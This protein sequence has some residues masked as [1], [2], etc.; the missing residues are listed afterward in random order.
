M[1]TPTRILRADAD[2]IQCDLPVLTTLGQEQYERILAVAETVMARHGAHTMTLGG[3]T[4]ALRMSSG[5]LRRHFSDI[6]GLLA[7]LLDRHLRNIGRA[8]GEVPQDAVD[9]PQKLRAAYLAT[10]RTSEGDFTDAH[11]LMVRARL[12]LPKGLLN[13]IEAARQE[14]GELV[15]PGYA[16]MT[17][18]VLDMRAL[19]GPSIEAGLAAIAAAEQDPAPAAPEFLNEAAGHTIH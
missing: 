15:G 17:I 2:N 4:L 13:G 6:D 14:L 19:D 7:T 10:T 12:L 16:A 8:L 11:K 9:R 3:L 5:A 1:R 18:D